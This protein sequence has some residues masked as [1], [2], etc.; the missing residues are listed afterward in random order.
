[1]R[2]VDALA[3]SYNQLSSMKHIFLGTMRSSRCVTHDGVTYPAYTALQIRDNLVPYVHA[4]LLLGPA[5]Q[6][7]LLGPDGLL[8]TAKSNKA[9]LQQLQ[10]YGDEATT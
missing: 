5:G 6:P 8:E 7:A 10:E 4:C 1:M 3:F 9:W 2:G